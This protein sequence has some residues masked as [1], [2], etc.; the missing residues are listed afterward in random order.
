MITKKI[1]M[2]RRTLT[3]CRQRLST[4]G[5]LLPQEDRQLQIRPANLICR[6]VFPFTKCKTISKLSKSQFYTWLIAFLCIHYCWPHL[7][8]DFWRI[9]AYLNG[10]KMRKWTQEWDTDW[11]PI[12]SHASGKTKQSHEFLPHLS[13]CLSL[14]LHAL[15]ELSH[16]YFNKIYVWWW[17]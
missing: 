16:W 10:C 15:F 3:G 8:W 5:L 1:L 14:S 17:N 7:A 11:L 13:C 2:S 6:S 9:D 12:W 4:S